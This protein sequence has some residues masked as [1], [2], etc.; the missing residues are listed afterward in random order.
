M[1]A[2]D[3]STWTN[4]KR[5]KMQ[6]YPLLAKIL[7]WLQYM[8]YRRQINKTLK[9][10]SD[11][12][13]I[14]DR[15]VLDFIV[16]QTVNYGDISDLSITKNLLHLVEKLDKIVFIDVDSDVALQRKTDIPSLEYLDER[17][18]IYLDYVKRL[19]NAVVINNNSL[20]ED[21]LKEIKQIL[22]L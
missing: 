8:E 3:Y 15:F 6:R 7:Y 9:G 2:I 19:P 13:L 12:N 22:E 1:T 4:T 21:A 11:K 20:I 10:K 17:R 5:A 16:D 14:I 18:N